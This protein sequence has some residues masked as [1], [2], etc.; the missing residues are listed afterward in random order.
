MEWL[1]KSA[2]EGNEYAERLIN[3]DNGHNYM[4]SNTIVSLLVDF[5]R[6]IEEDSARSRRNISH[7]ADKKLRRMIQKKK[8]ELGIKSGGIEMY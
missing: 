2:S 5:G 7:K 1:T 4:I 3:Y 6:I 8:Q